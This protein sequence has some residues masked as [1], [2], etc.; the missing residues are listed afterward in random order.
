M[1][2]F[3]LGGIGKIKMFNSIG[4]GVVWDS[5][6]HI[7][8]NY[9]VIRPAASIPLDYV[10]LEVHLLNSEG[11][12]ETYIAKIVGM[13]FD[14]DLAVL[15]ISTSKSNLKPIMV[16]DSTSIEIGQDC[17]LLG[18]PRSYRQS[19]NKQDKWFKS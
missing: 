11:V 7:V 18:A 16:E 2:N 9:H 8:T 6:G 10:H 13:D 3:G 19:C 15:K 17:F 12:E 1:T 4:S 5:D 14:I